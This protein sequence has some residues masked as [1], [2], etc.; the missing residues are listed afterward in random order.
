MEINKGNEMEVKLVKRRSDEKQMN[1][2]ILTEEM[3]T[4]R[5]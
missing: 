4:T 5:R 3:S 2:F 1:E